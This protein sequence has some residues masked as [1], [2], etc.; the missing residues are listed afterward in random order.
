MRKVPVQKIGEIV[1]DLFLEINVQI[2]PDIE[3]KIR[4][5]LKEGT[6]E[7]EKYVLK[8][9]LENADYAKEE[10]LP[11]CQ[12]TGVAVVFL[13]IGQDVYLT[14]GSLDEAIQSAVR[15]AYEKGYFR[16]SVV[17]D[18]VL[19]ENTKDNTPAFIHTEI[20]PGNAIK[21]TCLAKGGGSE[22][23]SAL[24]MLSPS[25]GIEGVKNFVLETV[26]K[27]GPNAC[28][29]IIVGVG[30]G[31]TFDG[32]ALLAKKA[33]L[34]KMGERHP[35]KAYAELEASLLK[36]MNETGIGPQGYGGKCTALE[37]F[38]ETAPCHIASLPVAVN[39][40]CHSARSKSRII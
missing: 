15:E 9:L 1:Q 31:S 19:R 7:Q 4:N 35:H 40:Q 8:I 16:K 39:I 2:D 14:D 27:A 24:V 30:I 36:K 10:R 23:S 6:S 28:P 26:K 12:D 38:V 32:C 13:E 34:R 21:I 37:V 25:A 3:N 33:I 20:V 5:C 29:P 11:L 17:S 18:P 22:N